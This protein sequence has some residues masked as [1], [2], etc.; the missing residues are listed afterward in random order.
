M[1]EIQPKVG[2]KV[3]QKAIKYLMRTN[4]L[5]GIYN[6]IFMFFNLLVVLHILIRKMC[7]NFTYTCT[8][9]F[10]QASGLPGTNQHTTDRA[11]G[12]QTR[13]SSK[14]SGVSVPLSSSAR[15]PL[16]GAGTACSWLLMPKELQPTQMAQPHY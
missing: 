11:S 10:S 9:G 2:C 1:V 13:Q 14:G 6:E 8:H 16:C 4:W 3:Q 15:W 5:C 7:N 12:A